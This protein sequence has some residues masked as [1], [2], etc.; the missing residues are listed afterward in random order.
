M[1]KSKDLK[2]ASAHSK[3]NTKSKFYKDSR[4]ST[5]NDS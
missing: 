4:K 2:S 1:S 5:K 3:N